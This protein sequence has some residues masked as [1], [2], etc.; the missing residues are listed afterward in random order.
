MVNGRK[1]S[2]MGMGINRLKGFS[3]R[4]CGRMVK[5]MVMASK[6]GTMGRCMKVNGFKIGKKGLGNILGLINERIMGH[7]AII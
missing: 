7:G 6:Y 5:D 3:T 4:A 1:V 2:T